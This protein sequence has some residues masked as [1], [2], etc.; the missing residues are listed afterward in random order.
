MPDTNMIIFATVPMVLI[1]AAL[2]GLMI[3]LGTYIHFPKMEERKRIILSLKNAIYI[4]IM[5]I[6]L[7][8]MFLI[9]LFKS[10]VNK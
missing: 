2:F 5:L 7:L 10:G 9:L 3:F 1:F 8:Y 6:V 4:I